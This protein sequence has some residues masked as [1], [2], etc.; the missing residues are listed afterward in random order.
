MSP[1]SK[2]LKKPQNLKQK[3]NIESGKLKNVTQKYTRTQK[4]TEIF[5]SFGRSNK[6]PPRMRMPKSHNLKKFKRKVLQN[7]E[8]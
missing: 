2:L 5:S 7:N 8:K 4:Y 6:S 3:Q 1:Q